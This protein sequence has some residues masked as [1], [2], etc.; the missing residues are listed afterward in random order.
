MSVKCR[1]LFGL[2]AVFAVLGGSAPGIAQPPSPL[3]QPHPQS[4]VLN[5]PV[6]LGIQRGTTLELTLT[7][8]N[9][10][11]PTGLWT[12]FPAKVVIPTDAKNGTDSAK[13]RVKLEVPKDAPLGFHSL[14]LATTRGMS[15]ARLFCVDD[16]PQVHEVDT[17]RS[18][19]TAQAVNVPCVVV[20]RADAEITDYFKITAT[21]G[22]RLSF[23][24]LGR[25]LG[26]DFDPELTLF[27]ARSGKP[28]PGGHSNDSPGC[29]TDPRLTYTFKNAGAY[30]VAIRDVTYRGGPDFW[31]RLRIGD[32]PCATTPIPMAAKRG[33]K[34][35][36][37]FAGPGVDGALP[38]EVMVPADPA[39]HTLWV[40]PRRAAG[41]PG[42]P[43][44]LTVTDLDETVEKEP[45]NVQAQATRIPVPGAITARFEQK[46]DVDYFVFAAKKG[47][48]LVVEAHSLEVG[49]PTEVYVAI[50]DAK[51]GQLAASNPMA[52]PRLDFTPPA[53]GDFYVYVEHLLL[54]S[55]PSES[56]RLTV[57][58]PEPGFEL[59]L[60]LDRYQA[61]PGGTVS[62]PIIL[63]ARHDYT[64]PI[65]VSVIGSPG[66]TGQV[67]IPAGQAPAPPPPAPAPPAATLLVNVK[68]DLHLGPHNILLQGKATVSGKTVVAYAS[69]QAILKLSLANLP[70]PPSTLLNQVGFAVTEKP[71]FTLT[72]KFEREALRGG[73]VSVTITATRAAGFADEIVL[74]AAG[75]PAN[76][77]FAAKN[78]AKAQ[79]EAKTQVTV[80]ATANVGSFPLTFVGKTK[81]QNKDFSVDALPV[82]LVVT[83]PFEL[84]V[85]PAAVKLAPG[86]KIA[87]KVQA[88]RK[89]GY[90]GPINLEVRNLPANVTASKPSIALGQE[91]ANV[92]LTAAANA[93]LGSKADVN[94]LGTA[95]AAANQ[96]NASPNITVN[97]MK[98]K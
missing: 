62:I 44:P 67:T 96:Q 29:Q 53:D 40:S 52:V 82:P 56:Y 26:S 63:S 97:V 23:E 93:A 6:P 20:G 59:S 13:L 84:K 88:I 45:N 73:P 68:P 7:G 27:D 57:T 36:V 37:G 49:S 98:K 79:N 58:P 4:P 43:V 24:V 66:I 83:L 5:P 80:P 85:E 94:V 77:V 22:Q 11:E 48:K 3:S 69:T 81:F 10:A 25:R 34:V 31:Y 90:Q 91:M 60:F 2:L 95:I 78:I 86:E 15:N 47:Q 70:Y 21:A 89:G 30:I 38:V 35:S 61:F 19:A 39:L 50:K 51:G 76:V 72:A 75:L 1:A 87:L 74:S 33:S 8:T 46:N 55:G 64:G 12:S 71:P 32:F 18:P 28:L 42:W 65:E 41:Q 16:L 9:L 54:I 17:N 14:R 92:E